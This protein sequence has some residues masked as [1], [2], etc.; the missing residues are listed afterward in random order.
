MG[1]SHVGRFIYIE[2]DSDL[3][4]DPGFWFTFLDSVK[5]AV[6]DLGESGLDAIEDHDINEYVKAIDAWGDRPPQD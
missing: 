2:A 6:E 1:Y 3:S 4:R 5:G